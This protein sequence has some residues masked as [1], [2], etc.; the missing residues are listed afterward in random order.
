MPI[1]A[2]SQAVLR[3]FADQT[4]RRGGGGGYFGAREESAQKLRPQGSLSLESMFL[5][6]YSRDYLVSTRLVKL[7]PR[8]GIILRVLL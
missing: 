2:L 3:M 8:M 5:L 7:V 1:R 4:S 6:F